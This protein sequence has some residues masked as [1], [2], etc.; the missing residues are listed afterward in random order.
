MAWKASADV[1]GSV[2]PQQPFTVGATNCRRYAHTVSVSGRV[3]SAAA[4]ACR[5]EDGVWA[6]LS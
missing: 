5:G 2:V 4:T 3:T 1:F 6:P